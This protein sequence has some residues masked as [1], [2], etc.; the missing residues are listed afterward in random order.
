MK[1]A[2]EKIIG[3]CKTRFQDNDERDITEE[4][5]HAMQNV[6]FSQN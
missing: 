3:R 4:D 6:K 2:P 1:G 5:L